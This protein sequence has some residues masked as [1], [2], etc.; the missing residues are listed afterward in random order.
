MIQTEKAVAFKLLTIIIVW[1]VAWT[2]FTVIT[3]MQ[4]VGLD[5]YV[6]NVVSSS[7]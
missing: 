5:A 3:T 4:F 1:V 7:S 6:N 2:P